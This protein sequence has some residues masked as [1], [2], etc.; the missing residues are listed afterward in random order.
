VVGD[1][2]G[3]VW[4]VGLRDCSVQRRNQKLVEES[5]ST[6]LSEAEDKRVREAAASLCKAAGYTGAGT[7]EFL[8]DLDRHAFSF[9]EV[10]ARLQVEHPVTELTTGVDLVKLQLHVAMG[11]RLE[12]GPPPRTGHAI[13]VRINAED[14]DNDFAPGPGT[15]DLFHIAAGPGLRVDTGVA[16]GDRIPAEF[17]SMIAKLIA[18]GRDRGEALARLSRALAESAIVI[19]GGASNKAFLLELLE[20]RTCAP[21]RSTSAGSTG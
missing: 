11:G 14:P 21:A 16:A 17:D 19:R 1:R 8:Y 6:V 13:E 10:N 7:V 18:W 9:M 4:A 5:A 3:T 20:T 2:D 15:I 12:G